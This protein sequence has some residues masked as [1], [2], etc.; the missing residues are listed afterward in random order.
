MTLT[1]VPG[2]RVGHAEVPG[3][4]SGC[5]VILGPFQ[6]AVEVRGMA[7]GTRELGVLSPF[8]LAPQVDAVVLSGG[9]AF[10][11]GAAEGV[12]DWLSERGEGFDA[13]VAR[14]PLVPAAV[15]FDLGPGLPRPGRTEGRRAAESASAA[16][17]PEGRVGAG[18]GAT[19][20]KLLGS[21]RASPGGLG[22]ASLPWGDGTVGALAVVNAVGDVVG[23]DGA[24]LAGAGGSSGTAVRSDVLALEGGGSEDLMPGAHTTLALVATDVPLSRVDLG[25]LARMASAAFPRA[26]SPVHTPFDGDI[27]FALSTGRTL[28]HTPPGEALSP[29]DLMALGVI[30]RSLVEEAI[31]RAV[32][33]ALRNTGPSRASETQGP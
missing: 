5:T 9:S 29:R 23:S 20:G 32:A 6:A 4:G 8:H 30:A 33:P 31:R 21:D 28:G 3:G 26:I 14:V 1:A 15:I 2:I 22:S 25:K 17:V 12:M 27:L 13:G 10:G 18:A 24:V 11:L 19:V 7:T 16:A